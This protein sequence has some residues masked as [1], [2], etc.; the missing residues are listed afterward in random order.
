PEVEIS[1]VWSKIIEILC[2]TEA[3]RRKTSN[4]DQLRRLALEYECRVNP[5]FPMPDSRK[6]LLQLKERGLAL[7]IVSNAQFYTPLLFSA[8]FG[9]AVNELGFD[10]EC[11]IWSYKELK[12]KPAADLFPKAGKFLKANHGID[13][14]ETVYVG[15]DMLNDIYT[16]RQAGCKTVL[17]AGDKRSLRLRENDPRCIGLKPDAT[18]TE[19][20]QLVEII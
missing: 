14:S 2:N 15:N 11:C 17:F 10:S 19:L 18:I 1:K 4:M 9:Q 7:G 13:L 3:L 16:A 5:V 20:S 6:T 8:F 12:A